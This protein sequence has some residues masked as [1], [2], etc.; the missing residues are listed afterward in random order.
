MNKL[1]VVFLFLAGF[2]KTQTVVQ[3]DRMETWSPAYATSGWWIPAA[4]ATW[5]SNT[6]VSPSTSAVIYGL[7]S[8]TS[9]IEQDWYSLPNV[10]GLNTS[11]PYQLK[12]RLASHTF[13]AP[14]AATRGVDAAD[15]VEVQVSTNGGI[16]YVQELR[17]TGNSNAQWPFTA[18][19]TIIHNANGIWTNSA[20][21]AGDVYQAPAGVTT[22]GPTTITLNLPTGISQVAIDILCRIN[23]AGEE[24]WIDDIELIEIF[25]LPVELMSFEGFSTENGNVIT[26]VTA[27]EHNSD[28][29]LIERTT[30]GEFNENSV[31]GQ[32]PAMG[33]TTQ[34]SSYSFVD[35][36]FDNAINYY[37]LVQVD[38][39]GQYKIYGPISINNL[40]KPRNVVK[41]INMLGQ[42]CD[43]NSDH[44]VFIE[45]YDD[46]TMEK[47]YR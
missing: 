31:I 20:A 26:W 30:T 41:I 35:N 8:G 37:Q 22:T 39:D 46:G 11:H 47:V 19:G 23:S 33:N 13:T 44:G 4:T 24:W 21:P 18:S 36:Q 10:T 6:S 9:T 16:S 29:Y 1:L 38:I 17:I 43:P 40:I 25:P 14:A 2:A 28:Y 32:K 27:T 7:G 15:I 45:I 42:E 3:F 34:Q 12:F 5:A